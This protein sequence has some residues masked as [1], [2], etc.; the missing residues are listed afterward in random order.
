MGSVVAGWEVAQIDA[1]GIVLRKGK[2]SIELT[3]RAY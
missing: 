2:Q 3:L 1:D